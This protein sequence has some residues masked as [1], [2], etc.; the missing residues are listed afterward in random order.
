MSLEEV[1]VRAGHE[2]LIQVDD[3]IS[4]TVGDPRG[5]LDQFLRSRQIQLIMIIVIKLKIIYVI[6]L[7]QYYL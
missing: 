1:A 7:L 6:I 2:V 4:A 3:N 5:N